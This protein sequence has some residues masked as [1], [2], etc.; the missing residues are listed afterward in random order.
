MYSII[1][2][3][4]GETNFLR[5]VG[6]TL[7]SLSYNMPLGKPNV[8]SLIKCVTILAGR[9]EAVAVAGAAVAYNQF[10]RNMDRLHEEKDPSMFVGLTE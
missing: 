8:E 10:L 2:C 1:S 6:A 4:V 7:S 9:V 3:P 5:K